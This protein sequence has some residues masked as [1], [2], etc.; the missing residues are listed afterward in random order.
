[1]WVDAAESKVYFVYQGHVLSAPFSMQ[2]SPAR[3]R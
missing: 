1:M 2:A 3:P